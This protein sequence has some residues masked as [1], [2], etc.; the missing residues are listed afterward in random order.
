MSSS[1]LR[2]PQTVRAVQKLLKD[3]ET[4]T[5]SS[6]RYKMYAGRKIM[7]LYTRSLTAQTQK[8]F[9]AA[10]IKKKCKNMFAK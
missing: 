7:F 1:D 5:T 10:Q 9:V 2:I 8:I 4:M 6:I 3:H